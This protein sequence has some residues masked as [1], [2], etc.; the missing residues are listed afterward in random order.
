[1]VDILSGACY[2]KHVPAGTTKGFQTMS[3]RHRLN[4][5]CI[6]KLWEEVEASGSPGLKAW[7]VQ[8][9]EEIDHARNR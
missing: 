7:R 3:T 6:R 9:F 8:R 1:V 2:V 5:R 4:C